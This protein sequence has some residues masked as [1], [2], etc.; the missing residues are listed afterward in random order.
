MYRVALRIKVA[1]WY[2]CPR[3]LIK[4]KMKAVN[5]KSVMYNIAF[6]V[7]FRSVSQFS[8]TS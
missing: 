8:Y 5:V 6:C 7:R 1:S 3:M 4:H 2:V